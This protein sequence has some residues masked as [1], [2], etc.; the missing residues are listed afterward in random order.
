[1]RLG[2]YER[3]MTFVEENGAPFE[4]LRFCCPLPKG[5]P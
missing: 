3:F 4:E 2:G 5:P 1:M